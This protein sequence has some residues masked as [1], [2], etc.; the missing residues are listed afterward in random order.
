[1]PQKGRKDRNVGKQQ[2]SNPESPEDN[3]LIIDPPHPAL[4]ANSANVW[5]SPDRFTA[6]VVFAE[7]KSLNRS[8]SSTERIHWE[9]DLELKPEPP[10]PPP[11][12]I[13]TPREWESKKLRDFINEGIEHF[14]E[15]RLEEAKLCWTSALRIDPDCDAAKANL[16]ILEQVLKGKDALH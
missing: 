13:P 2:S 6:K 7:D 15:Y 5:D 12:L 16:E 1:M 11:V 4:P 10:A 14:R 3:A 9:E 8:A